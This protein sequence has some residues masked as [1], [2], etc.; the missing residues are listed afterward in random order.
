MDEIAFTLVGFFHFISL[1]E[2]SGLQPDEK[3]MKN[4][5]L[6]FSCIMNSII[7]STP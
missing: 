7:E 1:F 3:N 5:Y 4:A 6:G 2:S